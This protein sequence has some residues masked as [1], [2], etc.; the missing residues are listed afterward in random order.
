MDD[1][2]EKNA[3]QDAQKPEEQASEQPVSVSPEKEEVA[4]SLFVELPNDNS[5]DTDNFINL[6]GLEADSPSKQQGSASGLDAIISNN[7]VSYERLPMLEVVFDRLVRM[8][9]TSLRNFTSDNVDVSFDGISS[10]RFGDYLNTVPLPAMISIFKAEEWDNHGLI[11]VDSPMIYS[12]V[13][14]LL[15]GRRGTA[16]TPVKIEH[17]PYTTIER[18]LIER[19]MRVILGD[20]SSSFDPICSINFSFERLETAPRLALIARPSNAALIVNF[21]VEMDERGGRLHLLL[22]Y[23]TLE[24]VR[25]L[26]LQNFMGERFGRDSI[27]EDHLAEQL[28]NTDVV[29]EAALDSEIMSLE[30]V[31]NWKVGEQIQLKTTP[32]SLVTVTCGSESL[33]TGKMGQKSGKVS[34]MIEEVLRKN[35]GCSV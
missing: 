7:H 19:M 30:K 14:V 15:G 3:D 17:R 33:F 2:V 28:W 23:A 18:N 26:L 24:P 16:S 20:L 8:M 22:P 27:W 6:L 12:V 1:D 10:A 4:E 31:L 11:I 32:E 5:I 13:D 34:I 25:D 35:K 9:S 21:R 29:I